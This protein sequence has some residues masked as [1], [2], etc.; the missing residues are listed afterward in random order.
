MNR[1]DRLSKQ[2][3]DKAVAEGVHGEMR[4]LLY[5]V[6]FMNRIGLDPEQYPMDK[7][8]RELITPMENFIKRFKVGRDDL[9]HNGADVR[10]T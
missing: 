8:H 7:V 4:C 5:L 1:I 9:Q 3:V 2:I 10:D 6:N